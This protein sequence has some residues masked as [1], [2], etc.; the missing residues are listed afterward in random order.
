MNPQLVHQILLAG[1]LDFD[2]LRSGSGSPNRKLPSFP[3][4]I[5]EL[6]NRDTHNPEFVLKRA[7]HDSVLEGVSKADKFKAIWEMLLDLHKSIRSLVPNRTDLHSILKDE[8]ELPSDEKNAMDMLPWIREAAQA[9][10]QL[11]SPEQ[12]TTTR[13]W[14]ELDATTT[15]TTTTTTRSERPMSFLIASIQY[16]IDKTSVCQEE[17][18]DFYLTQVVAPELYSSGKGLALERQYFAHRF[19]HNPSATHAWIGTRISNSGDDRDVTRNNARSRQNL[20]TQGWIEDVI[21]Q[22]YRQT[23]VPEIFLLDVKA[24]RSIRSTTR[25][26]AAGCALGLHACQAARC[27]PDI[28][29]KEESRGIPLVEVLDNQHG[30]T[31]IEQYEQSVED[32]VVA[33]TQSWS[34]NPI[35]NEQLETLRGQTRSVLRGEDPVLRLLDDRMQRLFCELG[36]DGMEDAPIEAMRT[37]LGGSH[38]SPQESPFVAKA[39]RKFAERGL[40][41]YASDL[42][43]ASELATKVSKLAYLLYGEQFLDQMILNLLGSE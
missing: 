26:A 35:Q 11:E 20:I 27:N 4:Y 29:L 28:L 38:A 1:P 32:A 36:V 13:A 23:T 21:F 5:E 30:H 34:E 7:Y 8:R 40:A 43:E 24:I 41:F 9:L 3:A 37:G 42:A 31:S 2:S 33:L 12:A 6:F 15:T 19:G 17:K 39:R 22:K 14:I 16:L 10:A 18:D 25:R